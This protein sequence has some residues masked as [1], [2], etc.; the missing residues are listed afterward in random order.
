MKI[1]SLTAENVKKLVAVEIIPQGNVVTLTGKN[2]SGKTSVLDCISWAFEGLAKVQGKPIRSGENKAWI[3]LDLG[4]YVVERTFKTTEKGDVTSAITVT[5]KDGSVFKQ[6]QTLLDTVFGQLSFDPLKF[7][8]ADRKEQVALL[9]SMVPDFDFAKSRAEEEEAYNERTIVNRRAKES[10]L[11]HVSFKDV[12]VPE[13]EKVDVKELTARLAEA[14]DKNTARQKTITDNEAKVR[15][16]SAD[17][18]RKFEEVKASED[19]IQE[20]QDTIKRL[21]Q[22]IIQAQQGL[23]ARKELLIIQEKSLVEKQN[24]TLAAKKLSVP[25]SVDVTAIKLQ[26]DEANTKN[27]LHDRWL[28]KKEAKEAV[29]AHEKAAQELTD[30]IAALQKARYNAIANAGLPITGLGFSADGVTFNGIPFDQC[31]SGEQLRV[32]VALAMLSNPKLKVIRVNDGSLLDSEG[33][34]LLAKM[35]LENDYQIWLEKTDDSG[36]VGIVLEEG[37]IKS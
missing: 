13:P 9:E 31:S 21:E 5:S 32:S 10:S 28:K 11:L 30:K 3:K 23:K 29:E 1:L 26:L 14:S 16:A 37:K 34:A 6:P 7:S 24:L 17:Q 19:N 27:A 20:L 15:E 4:E 8:R 18:N 12:P 35:A 36:N 25:D 2:G 33:L 22:E